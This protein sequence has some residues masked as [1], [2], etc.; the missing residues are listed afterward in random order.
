[1]LCEIINFNNLPPPPSPP[2]PPPPPPP[3]PA[4]LR[5]MGQLGRRK[6]YPLEL[7]KAIRDVQFI[8]NH[9]KRRDEYDAVNEIIISFYFY[10]YLEKNKTNDTHKSSNVV[11]FFCFYISFNTFVAGPEAI[12]LLGPSHTHTHKDPLFFSLKKRNRG[13]TLLSHFLSSL[14]P[15][16]RVDAPPF[17][18][19]FLFVLT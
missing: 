17:F 15:H 1:L 10:F 13:L 11:S 9:M 14:A 2:P 19:Y 18:S 4:N 6:R 7:Q 3:V 12:L 5:D 16:G 8:R